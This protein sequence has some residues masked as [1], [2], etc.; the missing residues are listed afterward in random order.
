MLLPQK[1]YELG[2]DNKHDTN[3]WVNLSVMT[4]SMRAF[5]CIQM[6]P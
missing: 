2:C 1:R 3:G 6:N 4:F 5:Y